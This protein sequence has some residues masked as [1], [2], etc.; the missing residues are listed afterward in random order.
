[1]RWSRVILDLAEGRAKQG[2]FE[3]AIA[4]AQLIPKDEPSVYTKAQQGIEYWKVLTLQQRQNQGIIQAAKKQIQ[5]NQAS[6]YN[7]AIMTLRKVPR[8]QPR[9]AEAQQLTLQWSRTIYLMAQSRASRGKIQQAIQTA[10]FVPAGTP[11]SNAAKDA[12]AKWRQGKR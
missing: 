5:P 12:I 8:G 7:R 9:Y 1:M 2:N 4:A 3:G 6:S 11:D 10:A